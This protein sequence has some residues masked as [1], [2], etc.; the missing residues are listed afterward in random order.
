MTLYTWYYNS[1]TTVWASLIPIYLPTTACW[2]NQVPPHR[3]IVGEIKCPL[4]T[5]CRV[6]LVK[7]S[8]SHQAFVGEMKCPLPT[9]C[10]GLLVKWSVS[11][12]VFVGEIKCLPPG[13]CWWNEVS[14]TGYLLMKWSVPSPSAAGACWWNE[15]S[16]TG[17]WNEVSPTGHLSVKSSVPPHPLPG[18][19]L[20]NLHNMQQ[21]RCTNQ[22][23]L[24]A[25]DRRTGN[26]HW[27]G[28]TA[29]IK[30]DE[31]GAHTTHNTDLIPPQPHTFGTSG[32][33]ACTPSCTW[34]W[35]PVK[36]SVTGSSINLLVDEV[37]D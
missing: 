9:C 18:I 32:P 23:I 25:F 29:R 8:V 17:R 14:P 4:P 13:I 36:T 33:Q 21:R 24:V 27:C 28:R 31:A 19:C 16:P 1:F 6:L 2:W 37:D 3:A 10:R 30:P 15:V 11:H 12:R 20:W 7:C 34:L 22:I 26:R 35:D 5:R